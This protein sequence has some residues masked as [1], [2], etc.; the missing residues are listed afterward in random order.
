[1]MVDIHITNSEREQV[2][3]EFRIKGDVKEY[4]A[5]MSYGSFKDLEF[6][7]PLDYCKIVNKKD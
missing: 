3:V 2:L 5:Q 6:L 1:M 4:T 7:V